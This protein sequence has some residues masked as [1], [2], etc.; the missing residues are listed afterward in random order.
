MTR[1]DRLCAIPLVRSDKLVVF[2]HMTGVGITIMKV[3]FLHVRLYSII[4]THSLDDLSRTFERYSVP[5]V[6]NVYSMFLFMPFFCVNQLTY[7]GCC[8]GRA[9]TPSDW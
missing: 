7:Q 9:V 8:C 1:R 6:L 3:N 2:S 5:I 4:E